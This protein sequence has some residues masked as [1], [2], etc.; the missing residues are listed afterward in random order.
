MS[1]YSGG[2]PDISIKAGAFG[3]G[4]SDQDCQDGYRQLRDDQRGCSH[5][6]NPRSVGGRYASGGSGVHTR[7]RDRHHLYNAQRTRRFPS[8]ATRSVNT[9]RMTSVPAFGGSACGKENTRTHPGREKRVRV[10]LVVSLQPQGG[11]QQIERIA[12]WKVPGAESHCVRADQG[13]AG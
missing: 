1:G 3:L 6:E 13:T 5:T 7:F 2:H 10:S 12:S 8:D 9:N 11:I 4:S